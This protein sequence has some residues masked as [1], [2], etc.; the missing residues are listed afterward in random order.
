M[1]RNKYP[2]LN[3]GNKK[4]TKNIRLN[5]KDNSSYTSDSISSE[6]KNNQTNSNKDKVIKDIRKNLAKNDA[7]KPSQSC[8][9][10]N[11]HPTDKK[12]GLNSKKNTASFIEEKKN[13]IYS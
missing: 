6:T 10:L 4:E 8:T 13:K 7:L 12:A 1:E 2:Y 3:I 11:S 9:E 5:L